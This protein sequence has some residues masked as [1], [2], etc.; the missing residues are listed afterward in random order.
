MKKQSPDYDPDEVLKMMAFSGLTAEDLDV[1]RNLGLL[2]V[3][4]Y[5]RNSFIAR[6]DFNDSLIEPFVLL[7]IFLNPL[8]NPSPL[9]FF[10]A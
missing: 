5:K 10:A 9:P 2:C 6:L 3:H 4:H 1:M 8:I 7:N